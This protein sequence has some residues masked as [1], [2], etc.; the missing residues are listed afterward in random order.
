MGID[1]GSVVGSVVG[2]IFGRSQRYLWIWGNGITEWKAV[3]Q[4]TKPQCATAEAPYKKQ[5]YTTTI[6]LTDRNPPFDNATNPPSNLGMTT[7]TSSSVKKYLLIGGA[8]LAGLIFLYL[9][10]RRK[11]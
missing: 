7:A 1:L 8:I 9:I 10:L 5:G 4:G 3:Y 11:K 6:Q 2:G